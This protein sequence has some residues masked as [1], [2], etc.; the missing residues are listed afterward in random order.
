[1]VVLI[2]NED[3]KAILQTMST[4]SCKIGQNDH[5]YTHNSDEFCVDHSERQSSDLVKQARI[6]NKEEQTILQD[7]YKAEEGVSYEP[8]SVD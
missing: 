6:A 8:G 1:M 7:I 5:L 4:L 2:F 3:L